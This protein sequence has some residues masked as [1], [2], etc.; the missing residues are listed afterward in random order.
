MHILERQLEKMA[1]VLGQERNKKG[2]RCGD[3]E[4]EERE[5]NPGQRRLQEQRTVGC[6]S[7]QREV[8]FA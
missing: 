3:A 4:G 5:I 8:Q 6:V 1:S 7:A 2:L